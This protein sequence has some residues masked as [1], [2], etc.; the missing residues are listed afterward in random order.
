MP[1]HLTVH[2][3]AL[4]DC[5]KDRARIPKNH[6]ITEEGNKVRRNTICKV[7]IGKKSK[8]LAL[9]GHRERDARILLDSSTREDMGVEVG[10]SYEVTICSVGWIG[11]WLWAWRAADP[12]YRLATQISLISLGLGLIGLFLGALSLRH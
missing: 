8:L 9:R 4:E 3:L 1:S 6:R 2:D 10:K 12:A 7:T 11:R 5:W